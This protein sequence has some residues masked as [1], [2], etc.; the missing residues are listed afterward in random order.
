MRTTSLFELIIQ[1]QFVAVVVYFLISLIISEDSGVS[2][3]QVQKLR[4]QASASVTKKEHSSEQPSKVVV[5]DDL[6]L[7][8]GVYTRV[9][10]CT[11]FFSEAKKCYDEAAH[12]FFHVMLSLTPAARY[13]ID[14]INKM[15]AGIVDKDQL[16]TGSQR[17]AVRF[18][19]HAN[20]KGYDNPEGYEGIHSYLPKSSPA[21]ELVEMTG[22]KPSKVLSLVTLQFFEQNGSF[23]PDNFWIESE[24]VSDSRKSGFNKFMRAMVIL[25]LDPKDA[26]VLLTKVRKIEDSDSDSSMSL[27]RYE[28]IEEGRNVEWINSLID[29]A[30]SMYILVTNFQSFVGK[31]MGRTNSDF[32]KN[33]M[34]DVHD[35][36]YKNFP[37]TSVLLKYFQFELKGIGTDDPYIVTTF[38]RGTDELLSEEAKPSFRE[39]FFK[40]A[41]TN[42]KSQTSEGPELYVHSSAKN[43]YSACAIVDSFLHKKGVSVGDS[44]CPQ[45]I[46]DEAAFAGKVDEPGSSMPLVDSTHDAIIFSLIIDNTPI[47]RQLPNIK[48]FHTISYFMM[49]I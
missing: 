38:R 1:L 32:V 17:L 24:T 14:K 18:S 20:P 34:A 11:Q 12:S 25:L 2:A 28:V 26:G 3:L 43:V 16:T 45:K 13:K 41:E 37:L 35:R 19:F 36:D 29:N 42:S 21:L 23:A 30:A 44:V 5:L 8:D 46:E 40:A 6:K 49:Q 39:E 15:L 4:T 10:K 7:E 9:E 31:S 22:G 47:N 33:V 27:N 48:E